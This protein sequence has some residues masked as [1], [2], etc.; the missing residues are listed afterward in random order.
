LKRIAIVFF[1]IIFGLLLHS[2]IA[3]AEDI[4][5]WVDEKG[6]V[7]FTDYPPGTV[8]LSVKPENATNKKGDELARQRILKEATP[9]LKLPQ[10]SY[11][12][13]HPE[14]RAKDA[15]TQAIKPLTD[16]YQKLIEDNRTREQ[17]YGGGSYKDYPLPSSPPSPPPSDEAEKWKGKER[18]GFQTRDNFGNIVNSRDSYQTRD[19]FGNIVNKP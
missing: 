14:E 16:M 4:Y 17:K 1:T 11:Y 3:H 9:N 15:A 18:A 12:D 10:K 2:Q 19:A 7:H 13:A 5:K 6:T 8:K